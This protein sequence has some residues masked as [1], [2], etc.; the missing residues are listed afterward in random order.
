MSVGAHL[1]LLSH[2]VLHSKNPRCPPLSTV[3]LQQSLLYLQGASTKAPTP[4]QKGYKRDHRSSP[5]MCRLFSVPDIPCPSNPLCFSSL[6][7][8]SSFIF[9]SSESPS[10]LAAERVPSFQK[11]CAY[12]SNGFWKLP[13][14][15]PSKRGSKGRELCCFVSK[16]ESLSSEKLQEPHNPEALN[17]RAS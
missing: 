1:S 9:S 5:R 2:S 3:R 13:Q 7:L 4:G 17:A 10:K 8:F 11:T 12:T 6:T 14:S 16:H 15:L